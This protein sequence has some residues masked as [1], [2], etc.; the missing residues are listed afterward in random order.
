MNYPKVPEVMAKDANELSEQ[1]REKREKYNLGIHH[2][3]N[4]P[5]KINPSMPDDERLTFTGSGQRFHGEEK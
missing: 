4:D 1:E 5:E 2:V 3:S